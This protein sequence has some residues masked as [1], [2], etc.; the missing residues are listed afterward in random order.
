M[1]PLKPEDLFKKPSEADPF[2]EARRRLAPF[3]RMTA[4]AERGDPP[5]TYVGQQ[6]EAK[7]GF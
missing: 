7:G 3:C 1:K 2:A 6:L 5:T 4:R